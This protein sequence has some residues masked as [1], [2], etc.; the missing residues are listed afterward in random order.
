MEWGDDF[1]NTLVSYSMKFRPQTRRTTG[2]EEFPS[3]WLLV[4][5]VKQE[6]L[7]EMERERERGRTAMFPFLE[8]EGI[9]V[10]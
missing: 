2:R 10:V 9:G 6:L 4:Q 5:H 3:Y 8:Q 1:T 7:V